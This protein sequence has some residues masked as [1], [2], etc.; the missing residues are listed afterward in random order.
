MRKCKCLMRLPPWKD[1]ISGIYGKKPMTKMP[2]LRS[3]YLFQPIQTA[4]RLT[5]TS[6]RGSWSGKGTYHQSASLEPLNLAT[7]NQIAGA[8]HFT[9]VMQQKTQD[10]HLKSRFGANPDVMV[11]S[12]ALDHHTI[13]PFRIS[14]SIIQRPGETGGQIFDGIIAN[15]M[16]SATNG[17]WPKEWQGG[18]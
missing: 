13:I 8:R 6:W 17:K 18:S 1:H 2:L 16:T 12:R 3:P 14:G 11:E 9:I 15:T 7:K 10:V 4:D 5:Q